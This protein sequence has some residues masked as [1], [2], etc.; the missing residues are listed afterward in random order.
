MKI[1]TTWINDYLDPPA[2]T[3]ELEDVLTRVGFGCE[4]RE[5]IDGADACL[6]LEVTSNRGD[7]VSVLGLARE[8]AAGTNRTLRLP[9]VDVSDDDETGDADAA[10]VTSV[11]IQDFDLC[12]YYSARIIRGVKVGPSPQ[13]LVQR[14]EAI[15]LRSVNNIVDITNFILMDMGQPLHAFDLDLLKDKRIVV[16]R[17]VK[18]ES[19]VSID[20][21]KVSIDEEMLVIAD[22]ERPVAIAGVMGGLDT[23]V[24]EKT[25]DILLEAAS[26]DAASVRQTSRRLKLMSDS[27]YRF[28]RGVHPA[29][30]AF[31]A[32]RATQMICELCG[33]TRVDGAVVATRDVDAPRSVSMRVNRCSRVAGMD[34]PVD[35]MIDIFSRLGFSPQHHDNDAEPTL[36]CTIPYDRLDLEREVD[37]IEEVVRHVGFENIPTRSLIEIESIGTQ[38][39][40]TNRRRVDQVLVSCG[41]HQAVTHSFVSEADARAFLPDGIGL[42]QVGDDRRKAEP[43]LQPSVL[44]GLMRCR[45]RNQDAGHKDVALYEQATVFLVKGDEKIENRNLGIL[46]DA[47]DAQEGLRVIRS[48]ID[49]VIRVIVGNDAKVDV[50]PA[51]VPWFVADGAAAVS[52]NGELIGTYGVVAP[53]TMAQFDLQTGVVVAEVDVARFFDEDR[54][55]PTITDMTQFP[56]IQRDL[57]IV[58]DEPIA[59]SKIQDVLTE[60]ELSNLEDLEFVGVYRGKQVGKG[61]KSLTMRLTFRAAD[62]TLRHD[63]I[64]PEVDRLVNALKTETGAE[65][66]V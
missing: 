7:C 47:T 43:I 23:E 40:V 34:I 28:E 62:R 11:E 39:N 31:A 16:R 38:V 1:T 66:R 55:L 30:V 13:W 32:E 15:G 51:S 3:E 17:G 60:T 57:S 44:P 27:S 6:D 59:W 5:D 54:A 2:T 35:Q 8:F 18:G 48:V 58:I 22:A 26:F 52:V 9:T 24:N 50:V 20:R 19:M 10:S 41:F 21:S 25:T 64:D 53:K 63:E 46:I 61:K 45:K 42:L 33:G 12:P 14:L 37:L 65:L 56:S 4:E 36:H 29:T 49:E